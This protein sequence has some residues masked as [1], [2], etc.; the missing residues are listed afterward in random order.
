MTNG[1]I[2]T[3]FKELRFNEYTVESLILPELGSDDDDI[4]ITDEEE[5]NED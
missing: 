1:F 4:D 5:E 3:M 2:A